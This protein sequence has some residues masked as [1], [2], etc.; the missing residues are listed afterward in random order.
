MKK[1]LYLFWSKRQKTLTIAG[2]SL[3]AHEIQIDIAPWHHDGGCGDVSRG[4]PN[5]D[6]GSV[7]AMTPPDVGLVCD[8]G[9]DFAF[10]KARETPQL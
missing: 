3:S 7:V 10:N 5:I 8:A 1:P 2:V 4:S 9:G 6:T